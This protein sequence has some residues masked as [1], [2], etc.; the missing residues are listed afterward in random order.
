M[1]RRIETDGM[2]VRLKAPKPGDVVTVRDTEVYFYLPEG[3]PDRTQAEFVRQESGRY[4]VRALGREW[5]IPMQCIEHEE[6]RFYEG[7]W[8][9]KW[10]RRVRRAQALIDRMHALERIKSLDR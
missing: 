2:Q 1:G 6:E 5:N 10:D 4:I 8:L 3:L 7:R 9:D